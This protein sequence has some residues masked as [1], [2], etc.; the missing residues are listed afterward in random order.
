MG[1]IFQK[2]LRF[3]LRLDY[4]CQVTHVSPVFKGSYPDLPG[5]TATDPDVG[6][7]YTILHRLRCAWITEHLRRGLSVPMPYS[8]GRIDPSRGPSRP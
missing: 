2:R 1:S 3:Y 8:A 7:L 6:R 4:P 5:V